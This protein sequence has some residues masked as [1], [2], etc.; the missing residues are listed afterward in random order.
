MK[1][2]I[3]TLCFCIVYTCGQFHIAYAM[4]KWLHLGSLF[5]VAILHCVGFD[6]YVKVSETKP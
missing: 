2:M 1:A 4:P 5:L 6:L 3:T